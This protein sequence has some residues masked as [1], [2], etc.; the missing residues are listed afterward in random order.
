[1]GGPQE[2]VAK[3]A[4]RNES[5][6]HPVLA[7]VRQL[8]ASV[9]SHLLVELERL[10]MAGEEIPGSDILLRQLRTEFLQGDSSEKAP[11]QDKSPKR[12]FFQPTEPFL[13]NRTAERAFAGQISRGSLST[14]WELIS[15]M[16]PAMK[17]DF[18]QGL[19]PAIAEQKSKD[20]EEK[21]GH[22]HTK[23]LKSFEIRL[24]TPDGVDRL[25]KDLAKY[26][27][28]RAAYGDLVKLVTVLQ[29]KDALSK[30]QSALPK[31]QIGRFEGDALK[32][33]RQLLTA[34]M[35]SNTE[36]MPFALK[37]VSVRLKQPWQLIRLAIE[38]AGSSKISDMLATRYAI[39]PSMVLDYLEERR[40]A[41]CQAMRDNRL[42]LAQ[43][44]LNEILNS[45]YALRR[46]V[47]LSGASDW[48][49]R[50]DDIMKAVTADV[51]AEAARIP[52]NIEHVLVAT[53]RRHDTLSRRL[54]S[55]VSRTLGTFRE[56]RAPEAASRL[57]KAR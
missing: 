1:M 40:Q 23:V 53:L 22:F 29:A 49:T 19:K 33:V 18:E 44:T 6:V 51:H 13:V 27:S 5:A 31:Q 25:R 28:S 26:T 3:T 8:T 24:A 17:Q 50:L 34:C 21:V 11:D 7:Y 39:I 57:T 43:A 15:D 52:D 9:R 41:L 10:Q 45:E 12:Y 4:E 46:N 14:I 56:R 54:V 16:L 35:D 42:V 37:A 2:T 32:R 47:T 38:V 20:I 30:F 36:G 55:L 48:A